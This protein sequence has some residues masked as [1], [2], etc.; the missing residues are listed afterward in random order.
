MY[1][2]VHLHRGTEKI[3]MANRDTARA[4]Q[5][6]AFGRRL[7]Q[8]RLNMRGP[9]GRQLYKKISDFTNELQARA[10]H[11]EARNYYHWEAGSRIPRDDEVINLLAQMLNTTAEWLVSGPAEE[12]N[13]PPLND[14]RGRINQTI[15]IPSI[16]P[17]KL[18]ALR[19]IPV[20]SASEI[21]SLLLGNGNL[22]TMSR[23]QLP[24]PPH[25][26]AGADAFYYR[27]PE[28][29]TSM[30]GGAGHSFPPGTL[31]LINRERPIQPGAFLLAQQADMPG[32]IMRQLQAPFPVVPANPRFP[33]RLIALNPMAQP[34]VCS[35]GES[36]EIL[37]RVVSFTQL[38]P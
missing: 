29:D 23:E 18:P 16:K 22:T 20:L 9:D 24:A 7:R 19:Y 1:K 5:K 14:N 30:V 32:P 12:V 35:A 21:R 17:F 36:W 37:G 25:T 38:L 2:F 11:L 34:I 33:F 13:A 10:P 15:E 4:Q 28:D 31:L 3:A 8:Q 6:R 26:D 27:I